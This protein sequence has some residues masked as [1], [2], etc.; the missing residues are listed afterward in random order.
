[1]RGLVCFSLQIDDPE[2][3][4]IRSELRDSGFNLT[5][6]KVLTTDYFKVFFFKFVNI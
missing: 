4:R 1:M 5:N 3:E 6:E 2:K